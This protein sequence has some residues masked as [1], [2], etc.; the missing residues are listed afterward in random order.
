MREG[1]REEYKECVA[2]CLLLVIIPKVARLIT[3]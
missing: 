1:G 2:Y 3:W